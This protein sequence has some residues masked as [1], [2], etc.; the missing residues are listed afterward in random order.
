[1]FKLCIFCCL[2]ILS[3]CNI[4]EDYKTKE[5]LSYSEI[6]QTLNTKDKTVFTDKNWYEIFGDKDLNTLLFRVKKSNL[7]I[8]Q[9]KER[10]LTV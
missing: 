7:T 3:A 6:K 8:A 10:L 9:S 4:G 1:M 2:A 5:Y